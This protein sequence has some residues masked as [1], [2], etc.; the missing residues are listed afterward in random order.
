VQAWDVQDGFVL[1]YDPATHRR[2][3]EQFRVQ[4]PCRIVHVESLGGGE[5]VVTTHTFAFAGDGLHVGPPQASGGLR[6]GSL[7][8]ACIGNDVYSMDTQSGRCVT[9][10]ADL[11]RS[12]MPAQA[13]CTID[14]SPPAF[15]LRRLV[16]FGQDVHLNF[17]GDA[18]LSAALTG[19]VTEK[20]PSFD[21]AVARARVIAKR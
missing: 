17:S 14:D 2:V 7:L 13:E 8:T 18:L 11:T 12:P 21:A 9:W 4:S 15:I 3:V 5:S 1:I 16:G 19:A 6:Q 20:A 10:P